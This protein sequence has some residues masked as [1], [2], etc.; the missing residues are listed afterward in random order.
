M[1]RRAPSGILLVVAPIVGLA[2]ALLY[3]AGKDSVLG[4]AVVRDLATGREWRV[5]P[6]EIESRRG[7]VSFRSGDGRVNLCNYTI[8]YE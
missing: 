4:T 2:L 1:S 3:D 7:C 5:S 8:R 6:S